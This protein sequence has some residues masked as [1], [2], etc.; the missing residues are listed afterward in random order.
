[1]ALKIF[2]LSVGKAK[3]KILFAVTACQK[4]IHSETGFDIH[5]MLL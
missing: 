3:L 4:H 2:M 5:N 1:M